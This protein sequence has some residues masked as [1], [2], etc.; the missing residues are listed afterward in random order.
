MNNFSEQQKL[1]GSSQEMKNIGSFVGAQAL[2]GTGT[3]N[4]NFEQVLSPVTGAGGST[5]QKK[6]KTSSTVNYNKI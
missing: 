6:K 1:R 2:T 5:G 3:Q 4:I